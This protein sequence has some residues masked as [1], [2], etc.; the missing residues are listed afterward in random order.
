M[1]TLSLLLDDLRLQGFFVYLQL[2]AP[3]ALDVRAP[4]AAH[5][6]IVTE[7]SAW[8]IRPHQPPMLLES[9]DMVLLPGGTQHALQ[10][11]PTTSA[12]PVD[13]VPELV[14]RSQEGGGEPLRVGGGSGSVTRTVSGLF[15]F[16]ADMAAPLLAA[17]PEVIHIRGQD[18]QVAP[19]LQHGLDFLAIETAERR[20]AHQAIINRLLDIL[21][22]EAVREHIEAVPEG[23][24]TWLGALRDKALSA[25]LNEMHTRPAHDW[26]VQELAGI[27]FLSRSAFAERFSQT[28]GMP[29]LAYLTRHRM[30][31]AARHLGSSGYA[32][33]RVAELVGYGSEAAFS[34]AFKR[35]YGVPPSVWRDRRQRE[36]RGEAPEAD[37]RN[38]RRRSD[39]P[40]L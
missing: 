39:A 13:V 15:R 21:L 16:D 7:G 20:P 34:Q 12:S 38:A 23:S 37:T 31:L 14:Q 11:R 35:E 27:A 3:W 22:I 9:G 6:H 32:V 26:T 4:Q 30:R 36:Q 5:F 24:H 33:A 1:D 10:D 29:P 40:E 28:I 2:T 18:A 25:V 19:W 8:L 17:L